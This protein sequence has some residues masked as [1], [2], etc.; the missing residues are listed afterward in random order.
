VKGADLHK[1]VLL[2]LSIAFIIVKD[3]LFRKLNPNIEIRKPKRFDRLTTLSQVEGQIPMTQIQNSKRLS[4]SLD[5]QRDCLQLG[6][7]A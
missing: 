2:I 7:M 4:P 1:A 6:L 3:C 5:K